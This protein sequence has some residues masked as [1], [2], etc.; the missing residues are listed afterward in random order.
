MTHVGALVA[1]NPVGSVFMPDGKTYY[2]WP[3]E[4]GDEFGANPPPGKRDMIDP[5]PDHSRLGARTKPG[6]N[7]TIAIVAT[8]ADLNPAEAKRVAIMAHDGI[9]RAIRPAHTPF[10]GDV[11]FSVAT[12]KT[13]LPDEASL[14]RP[15][16]VATL[17]AAA[18]D[19]LARA[20]ARA[21]FHAKA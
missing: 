4:Q 5:F 12:G 18:A 8:S 10:D 13:P 21:V 1:A 6:A 9:A 11:V 7:T 3:W 19:C 16:F 2:A 20:I 14:L 15:A 17:G